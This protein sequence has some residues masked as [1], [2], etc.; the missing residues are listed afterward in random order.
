MWHSNRSTTAVLVAHGGQ[1]RKKGG[2]GVGQGGA[3]LGRGYRIGLGVAGRGIVGP[4]ISL[5]SLQEDSHPPLLVL[6]QATLL[7][8]KRHILKWGLHVLL[9][10]PH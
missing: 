2:R 9:G 7:K 6:N 1:A 5:I 4:V 8:E 10:Q 3:G